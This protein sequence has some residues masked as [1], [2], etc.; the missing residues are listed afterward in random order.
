M[1]TLSGIKTRT[2]QVLL[3]NTIKT[4]AEEVGKTP[5][6]TARI[7]SGYLK[8]HGID[9][10]IADRVSARFLSATSEE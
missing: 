9:P 7:L 8:E 1:D 4:F 3:S 2:S 5:A 6:Q 10:M